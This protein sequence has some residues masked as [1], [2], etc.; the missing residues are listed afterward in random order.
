MPA[1][2]PAQPSPAQPPVPLLGTDQ[3]SATCTCA[4][5]CLP[6]PAL[7]LYLP[8][9]TSS[10]IFPPTTPGCSLP[11]IQHD[12]DSASTSP[13][14]PSL[15]PQ[16]TRR[17]PASLAPSSRQQALPL[18]AL[19][20][21]QVVYLD[22]AERGASVN[23]GRSHWPWWIF[24]RPAR[25]RSIAQQRL[26][27]SIAAATQHRACLPSTL[28]ILIPCQKACTRQPGPIGLTPAVLKP[29]ARVRRLAGLGRLTCA[30][31][32]FLLLCIISHHAPA[33]TG[34]LPARV[35]FICLELPWHAVPAGIEILTRRIFTI[36]GSIMLLYLVLVGQ[37]SPSTCADARANSLLQV[38][39]GRVA[40]L[41]SIE[42]N[43]FRRI[44]SLIHI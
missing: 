4:C 13:P 42:P 23:S 22:T 32:R 35:G 2:N 17:I 28:S 39:S 7:H 14:P 10:I 26:W 31:Q 15:P 6:V 29:A 25:R 1:P 9:C 34:S 36:G 30:R 41:V 40:S 12:S 33:K 21:F 16:T 44:L 8:A 19:G 18:P 43:C 27:S 24:G 11:S 20:A 5:L 37:S 3:P 38:A